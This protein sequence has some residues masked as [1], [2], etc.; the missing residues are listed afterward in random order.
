MKAIVHTKYGPPGLPNL[1]EVEKS[2]PGDD[3]VLIK[4]HAASVNAKDRRLLGADPVPDPPDGPRA[5]ETEAQ[6]A[7][8]RHSGTG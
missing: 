3:E 8:S 4:V 2:T 1:E 5:P 7:R 6:D